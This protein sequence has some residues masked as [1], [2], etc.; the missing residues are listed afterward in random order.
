MTWLTAAQV[1]EL[2]G[3]SRQTVSNRASLDRWRA[4][5]TRPQQWAKADVVASYRHAK[6]RAQRTILAK[7]RRSW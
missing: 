7:A 4:K 5:G 3:W 1:M 6:G 2:T